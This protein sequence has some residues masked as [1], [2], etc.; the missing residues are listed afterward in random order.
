MESSTVALVNGL[1]PLVVPFVVQLARELVPKI[2]RAMLPILALPVGVGLEQAFASWAG[3]AASP[4][5]GA[6]LGAAGVWVREF[7]HTLREHGMDS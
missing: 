6:L 5:L 4:I 1:I 3:M 2:P 7:I